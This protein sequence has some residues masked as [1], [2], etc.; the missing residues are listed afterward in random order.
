[1]KNETAS[2]GVNKQATDA[3]SNDIEFTDS[4]IDLELD[5]VVSKLCEKEYFAKRKENERCENKFNSDPSNIPLTEG[6]NVLYYYEC[7]FYRSIDTLNI[8]YYYT[9]LTIV[10]INIWWHVS[11]REENVSSKF[12]I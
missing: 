1:M 2:S 11:P 3:F 10:V 6:N 5:E 9:P 8:L 4:D 12:K 7:Q